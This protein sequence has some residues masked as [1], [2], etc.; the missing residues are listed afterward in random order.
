MWG[1]VA[2]VPL[3]FLE[4]FVGSRNPPA[5]SHPEF[6]YGFVG[7][8]LTWQLV[9]LTIAKDPG[10][11]RPFMILAVLEKASYVLANLGLVASN[12]MIVAAAFPSVWDLILGLLFIAAF[13]KTSPAR[14]KLSL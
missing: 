10:R 9:F 12:K 13:I 2:T 3:Y 6:Y 1:I 4:H 11:Y 14:D 7:V 8:T 5:I